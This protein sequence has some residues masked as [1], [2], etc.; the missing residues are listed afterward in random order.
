MSADP[1]GENAVIR[2]RSAAALHMA[3]NGHTDLLA[4]HLLNLRADLIRNGLVF[5]CAFL[6]ILLIL[7]LGKSRLFF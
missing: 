4:R 2:D 7:F 6:Q 1:C 3:R 5:R